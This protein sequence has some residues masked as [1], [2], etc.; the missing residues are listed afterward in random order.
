V[1]R[2]QVFP[3]RLLTVSA[4]SVNIPRCSSKSVEG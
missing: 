1:Y 3:M 2:S 4:L